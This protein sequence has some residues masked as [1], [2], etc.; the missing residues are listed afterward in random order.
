M[1]VVDELK[2]NDP[3]LRIVALVLMSGLAV[4][5]AGLWWVQIVSARQYRSHLETQA[6]RSVRLPAMR[7]KIL[8]R[9]GRVLAENVA[10]YNLSL[11]LDDLQDRFKEEYLHIRPVKI[12]TNSPPFW[13]F[14]SNLHSI[15]TNRA[16]LT[17]KQ[18]DQLTWQAR[19]NVANSIVMQI[20]RE[21]Q[22]SLSL[23][24]RKFVRAYM[25]ERALPLTIVPDAD[26][27]QVARFEEQNPGDNGAALDVQ[28]ARV[29]PYGALA[30][31]LIGYVR[32]DDSSIAGEDAFFDYRLPDFSGAHTIGI[33]HGL[34]SQL[35]GRAGDA[36]VLV[37][38]L[39][40]RQSETV[41][42]QPEP[43][44][45]VALTIDLDIQRT[46]EKA[47]A[48]HQGTNVQAAAV[49]M[50]VHTGD[51]LAMASFPQFDPNDFAQGLS[52]EEY[53]QIQALDAERN[54]ATQ[55]NY[56][57][58]S[59]FKPIV[60]LAALENGLNPNEI[61][62][63]QPNP[64]PGRDPS[65]IRIGNR[66]IGDT[67]PPGPYNFQLAIERSSNSYF[68]YNGLRTGIDKVIRM[69]EKFHFGEAEDLPTGQETKGYLPTLEEV[70]ARDWH[71]GDSAFICF[72]QGKLDVTPLQ[73][74]VAYS[75]IANGGTV[76]WPRLVE[77]IIPQ[78]PTSGEAATVFPSGVVR[79]HI[80]VSDHS[81]QILREA[82]LSE[83]EDPEG[84]GRAAVVG[85]EM[86]IC[87]KTGTAQVEDP[88][89]HIDKWNYWF[90]SF[91]PYENP[92]YAVVVMVQG[93][94]TGSG[95]YICA[96]IA[97][98]IYEELLK[99][100]QAASHALV[101]N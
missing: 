2:K 52:Q 64:G 7:G 3:Q 38:N 58:G 50:D 41:W 81:L 22:Q 8:D 4:L 48:N 62:D 16:R 20:S 31:H 47:I 39:G 63:V 12:V 73:I 19:Y 42:N 44:K 30:A 101:K 25:Q 35:H 99:K 21:L 68:I 71:Q 70:H 27:S 40:Y 60:G 53:D 28:P 29:Y 15:H 37:N 18:I 54:H 97:H 89:G 92:K 85:Q 23:D 46:A 55:E 14:W 79:D 90:A 94:F 65:A 36:S 51:V 76:L 87:G 11:Y 84:T 83:T 93:K 80:G 91:A 98:D 26:E 56:A 1:L 6:Y 57:P 24:P 88:H 96:P 86:R 67:V 43:G 100:E 95:G 9:E 32:K 66:I 33:E 49:V 61:Y 13:E 45:N 78:D 34:D 10:S 5:F 74:A 72:G 82:M 77:K 75:A 17:E 59:I 69:A